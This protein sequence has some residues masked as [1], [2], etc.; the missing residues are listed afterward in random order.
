VNLRAGDRTVDNLAQVVIV[1][2]G[3]QQTGGAAAD[4]EVIEL[5]DGVLNYRLDRPRYCCEL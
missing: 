5:R 2:V 4:D 1:A 3:Q